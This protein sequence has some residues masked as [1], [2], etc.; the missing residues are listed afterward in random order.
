MVLKLALEDRW[1]SLECTQL[2]VQHE[3]WSFTYTVV[4]ESVLWY[5]IIVTRTIFSYK[6]TEKWWHLWQCT[7][8]E[9]KLDT[10]LEVYMGI[11][12]PTMYLQVSKFYMD[13]KVFIWYMYKP[14]SMAKIN[15]SKVTLLHCLLACIGIKHPKNLFVAL[16]IALA[17]FPLPVECENLRTSSSR[18]I[19]IIYYQP[20]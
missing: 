12:K 5:K 11:W 2:Q 9:G 6:W 18:T 3:Q 8:I 4:V 16:V 7:N 14:W 10:K 1:T 19:Y 17:C 20:H 15:R 13:N